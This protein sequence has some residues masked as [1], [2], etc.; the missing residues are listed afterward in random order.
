MFASFLFALLLSSSQAAP[1]LPTSSPLASTLSSLRGGAPLLQD[2]AFAEL[3]EARDFLDECDGSCRAFPVTVSPLSPTGPTDRP[4]DASEWAGKNR[5]A[6]D[7]LLPQHGAVL[8]RG[9]RVPSERE[10]SEFV[11]AL[12][13][14]EQPYLGGNAVR[15]VVADRVFTSNESPPSER[16]PFHHEM[17]QAPEFPSKV[18]FY[19]KEPSSEGGETPIVLSFEVCKVLREQFGELYE[20]F[21]AEGVRYIRTMPEDDDAESALGRGWKSTYMVETREACEEEMRTAGTEWE[22]LENGDLKTTSKVLSAIRDVDGKEVFFNQV[23]AAFTGWND[24]RNVSTKAI[25]F[26]ES[27]ETLPAA[28]MKKLIKKTDQLS[29]AFEWEQGDILVIDNRL[30]MHSRKPFV[31]PRVVLASLAR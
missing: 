20:R 24:K 11:K 10:F 4:M 9:F 23:I 30:A 31:K 18:M 8:L 26:G 27:R 22:W 15:R 5:E 28:E 21:K 2:S 17:A 25:V 14:E 12:G 6:L 3:D 29:V 1:F 7:K 13:Y 19:C 16:I